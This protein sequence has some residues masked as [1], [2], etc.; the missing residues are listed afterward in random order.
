[1][2]QARSYLET[3]FIGQQEVIDNIHYLI[4]DVEAGNNYNFMFRAPSGYGKTY[5]AHRIVHFIHFKTLTKSYISFTGDK[6]RYYQG[7][8]FQ[9]IDEV[10]LLKDPE[11]IYPLMDS[12]QHTFMLMS[13]EYDDLLEPLVNRCF[14]FNFGPYHKEDLARIASKFF[15]K[16]NVILDREFLMSLVDNSRLMPREV[17]NL[18]KRLVIIFR[19]RGKP[20][21]I[22]EMENVMFNFCGIRR[23][24]FTVNDEAYL[25]FLRENG[26]AGLSTL[27]NV[28][29]IP[30]QI[31]INE[32]EPFLLRKNLIQITTRGRILNDNTN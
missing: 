5:L 2:W 28:L 22:R 15:E 19:Q 30:R 17:E 31:I 26:R 14:V 3:Y 13:N 4:D 27:V 32:I 20:S 12:G 16:N 11:R 18:C 7:K 29:Q 10:H 25:N 24:G 9:L 1:M 6:W 8:R 23:G 21:T